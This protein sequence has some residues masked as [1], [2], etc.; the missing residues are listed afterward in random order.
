MQDKWTDQLNSIL[1]DYEV[2]P[3]EGLWES[4]AE[5]LPAS[6]VPANTGTA[7]RAYT[8]PVR[9]WHRWVNIAAAIMLLLT[10]GSGIWWLIQDEHLTLEPQPPIISSITPK[11][12]ST[13]PVMRVAVSKP[14]TETSP[15]RSAEDNEDTVDEPLDD[16]E[17]EASAYVP[18]HTSDSIAGESHSNISLPP[19]PDSHTR[20]PYNANYGATPR[21]ATTNPSRLS[22]GLLTAYAGNHSSSFSSFIDAPPGDPNA[23][24]PEP[25]A[26]I[27]EITE[28]HHDLPV[29]IGITLQYPLTDR[30]GLESGLMYTFLSSERSV[31]VPD[32]RR[33]IYSYRLH[34]LGIPLTL[35]YRLNR[36][37]FHGFD[38]YLSAGGAVEKCV[39]GS[40]RTTT[41]VSDSR[42]TTTAPC[43]EHPWQWSLTAG[44]G[45]QYR[46]TP[47]FGIYLEPGVTFYPRASTPVSYTHMTQPTHREV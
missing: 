22:I 18:E 4:L 12:H 44:A 3:P 35:K 29:R 7:A 1:S 20:E 10:V 34:Y 5:V 41:F 45:L 40:E 28:T 9:R 33:T 25:D 46:P 39:S 30:L 14:S 8:A 13:T 24:G 47:A 32:T 26:P 42:T 23:N 31:L 19:A 2:T 21:R 43:Q 15:Y 27:E 37:S 11:S 17:V 36:T 38:A 16:I 6:D